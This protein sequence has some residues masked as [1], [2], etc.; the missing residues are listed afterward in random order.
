[1]SNETKA[2][3]KGNGN[4][5]KEL[6]R[7]E[8]FR[9]QVRLALPAHL[10]PERFIRVALTAMTR[11][12][13]LAKC[14]QESFFKCLLDLSAAG[15][16]P[17]GRRAHLIPYRNNKAGITE[18]TLIIDY[19]GL[20][21]LIMRSGLVSTIHADIVC[22]NDVFEYNLGEITRHVIDFKAP[23]GKAYAAYAMCRL[24]DGT[25][26]TEVMTV[27]EIERI[28]KRSRAG[29]SGPWVTDW[30][31]MA[32]KTAFRRLSKWLPL[33]A[34]YRDAIDKDGDVIETTARIVNEAPSSLD[35]LADSLSHEDDEE[36]K[37]INIDVDGVMTTTDALPL[38]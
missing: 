35:A 5:I 2:L 9:E 7:G 29:Q 17:D 25:V 22:E 28:R 26:K 36:T 32:K 38:E 8:A 21:E 18:C 20:V 24:K 34:E 13:D 10:K 1:M 33:S 12:P 14:T 27:E 30:N 19:K 16:E 4:Q 37:S 3:V 6:L 11:T 31:E 15:L 23:R